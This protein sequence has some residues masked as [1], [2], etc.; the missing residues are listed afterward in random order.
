MLEISNS[1]LAIMVGIKHFECI[2]QILESFFV[3][4]S[5]LHRLF[6][7]LESKIPCFVRVN[8]FFHGLYLIFSW[9]EI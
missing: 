9:I 2:Y 3:F 8:L 7:C 5:F 4:T 1:Y 6:Q